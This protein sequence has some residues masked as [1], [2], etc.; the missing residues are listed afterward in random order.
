MRKRLV[1]VLSAAVLVVGCGATDDYANDAR[2]PAP[3][4]VSVS[5]TN[6]R[7]SV[8]P[9]RIGAGPVVLLVANESDE[10]RDIQLTPPEGSSSACIDADAS[11]GPINP[12]GT[13]R[14]S[15]D[16]VEG[17]CIVGVRGPRG[18]RPARLTVGRERTSAQAD[19]LSP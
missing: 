3:R 2:P 15:L 1:G 5:V 9:D 11:S 16:L 8:S 19:L 17:D 6:E 13:A 7:V 4:D 14:V 18:P 12:R 10:S